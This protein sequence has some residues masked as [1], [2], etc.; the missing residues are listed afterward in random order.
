MDISNIL[1]RYRDF[2]KE[3][4]FNRA[5][6]KER[7]ASASTHLALIHEEDLPPEPFRE[8]WIKLKNE[9]KEHSPAEQA[10]GPIKESILNMPE[11]VAALF[12]AKYISLFKEI[13]DWIRDPS[14][15]QETD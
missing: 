1:S 7:F 5:R 9:L 10:L 15:Y 6:I 13:E 4:L 3:L 14:T 2:E 8:N 11:E 12:A